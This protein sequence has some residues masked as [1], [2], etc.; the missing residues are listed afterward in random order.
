LGPSLAPAGSTEALPLVRAG[1]AWYD[2]SLPRTAIQ[3][4]RVK[5]WYSG[6]IDADH[7]ALVEDGLI[8]GPRVWEALHHSKGNEIATVLASGPR[9]GT[10]TGKP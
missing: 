3:R 8:T 10:T 5:F 6:S 4:L 1:N 9:P 2:P 7:P